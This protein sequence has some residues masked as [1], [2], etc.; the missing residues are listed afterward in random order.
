MLSFTGWYWTCND[1]DILYVIDKKSNKI[2][3]GKYNFMGPLISYLRDGLLDFCG[4]V[5]DECRY[6]NQVWM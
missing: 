6:K 2:R 1:E 5:G 4:G 3:Y